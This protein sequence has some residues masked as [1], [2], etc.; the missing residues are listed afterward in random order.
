[1]R[2][3][4]RRRFARR[5]LG[6][7]VLVAFGAGCSEDATET[8]V[9]ETTDTA[10]SD[11]NAEASETSA[12]SAAV[13]DT[14]PTDG[15]TFTSPSDVADDSDATEA[16]TSD[17]TEATTSDATEATTSD[18]TEATTSDA[19]EATTSDATN[20]TTADATETV[21]TCA[22]GWIPCS[23]GTQCCRATVTD[24]DA[25]YGGIGGL[26][27]ALEPDGA[28]VVAYLHP[29]RDKVLTAKQVQ[30]IWTTKV[31]FTGDTSGGVSFA[32][33]PDGVAGILYTGFGADS[34]N[35]IQLRT[36]AAD[37]CWSCYGST[38]A[39]EVSGATTTNESALAVDA[40]GKMHVVFPADD[41]LASEGSWSDLWHRSFPSAVP[42]EKV[43]SGFPDAHTGRQPAVAIDAADGTIHVS[44]YDANATSLQHAWRGAD[45]VWHSETVDDDGD[46][47]GFS[48]IALDA[49]G[50]PHITYAVGGV[51]GGLKYAAWD[52]L[53]W[54]TES[55]ANADIDLA[56]D[57]A[58]DAEGRVHVLVA[59]GAGLVYLRKTVGHWDPFVLDPTPGVGRAMS[60]ALDGAGRLHA[61]YYVGAPLP[62][63][64][65]RHLS[66]SIAP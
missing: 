37:A 55:L 13:S 59:R 29:D 44:Y 25:A 57:L 15:A 31:A 4:T 32:I 3:H 21:S 51:P 12:D 58:V 48:A 41:R 36:R 64:S 27:L 17:A 56:S 47:G 62:T 61:A 52:G 20:A 10:V 11:G 9:A 24:V 40:A 66:I 38:Y 42:A 19:T 50:H 14:G 6:C 45:S 22:A 53:A 7:I 8:D 5:H 39:A 30:G 1:M 49:S 16:T 60:I 28:P 34:V 18:A 2:A 54:H 23:G 33:N 46:V 43:A 35:R 26:A 65:V 63:P